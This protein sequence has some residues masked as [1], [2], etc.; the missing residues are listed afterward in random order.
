[1]KLFSPY[2]RTSYDFLSFALSVA[3][4]CHQT[5]FPLRGLYPGLASCN[6]NPGQSGFGCYF[7]VSE[8]IL[9]RVSLSL[10]AVALSGYVITTPFY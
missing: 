10:L 3:S 2:N 8:H 7:S 5:I 4:L 9:L 1:M 6:A